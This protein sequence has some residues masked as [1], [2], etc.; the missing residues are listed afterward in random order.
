M[1]RHVEA[2]N[3]EQTAIIFDSPVTNTKEKYTY[4]QLLKEVET[5]AGVLRD[6]GVKKG[7]VVLVYCEYRNPCLSR[8][9]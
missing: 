1:D 2:G 6:E 4:R 8:D 3:G 9:F 7:D 5:F